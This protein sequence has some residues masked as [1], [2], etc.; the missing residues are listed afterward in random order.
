MDVEEVVRTHLSCETMAQI[1]QISH[2]VASEVMPLEHIEAH[3]FTV[4]LLGHRDALNTLA[5]KIGGRNDRN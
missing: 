1:K 5:S 3:L 4:G 2:L